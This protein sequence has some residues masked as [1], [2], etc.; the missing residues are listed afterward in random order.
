MRIKLG[1]F[2]VPLLLLIAGLLYVLSLHAYYVG[3][4]NDDAFYIIGARSLFPGN[5][6][7]S[8][9]SVAPSI[10]PFMPAY[11]L[12]LAPLVFIFP[13]TFI[14]LQALS[15]LLTLGTVFLLA[16]FIGS[17][18]PILLPVLLLMAFNPLT[19]SLSGTVLSDVPFTFFS[20]LFIVACRRRWDSKSMLPWVLLST[21]AAF[22][23]YLRPVGSAMLMALVVTLFLGRRWKEGIF[24]AVAG[25]LLIAPF[26]VWNYCL[27]GKPLPY[28][29][30]LLNPY[31]HGGRMASLISLWVSNLSYYLHELF[32]RYLLRWP[33][34]LSGPLASSLIIVFCCLLVL[35]GMAKEETPEDRR[36]PG[37]L[38]L[39]PLTLLFYA[40][41]HVAWAWNAGRYLLPVLPFVIYYFFCGVDFVEARF[42]P[43]FPLRLAVGFLGLCLFLN[44]LATIVESSFFKDRPMSAPPRRTVEWIVRQTQPSQVIAAE[45]DGQLHLLTGRRAVRLARNLDPRGFT[46]WLK[47]QKVDFVAVFPTAM[48]LKT[49]AGNDASDPYPTGTLREILKDS[50]SFKPVFHD[51]G[52]GSE[53]YRVL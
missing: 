27:R 15:V 48:S 26:L 22:L 47:R 7:W 1:R 8:I 36:T 50:K 37:F 29:S 17:A 53:I 34:A 45:L 46:L 20:L 4:F 10:S 49:A 38:P 12:L 21:L 30:Q 25:S 11:P 19:V 33:A 18:R 24:C 28:L 32:L 6:F 16:R 9:P 41:V 2:F 44:P 3:F 31:L 43:K 23:F 13:N 52:E 5:P 39:I 40:A 14:P 35:I 42:L 51:A